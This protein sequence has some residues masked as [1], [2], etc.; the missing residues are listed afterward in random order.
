MRRPI[1]SQNGILK[2]PKIS[3]QQSNTQHLKILYRNCL[4]SIHNIPITI[5]KKLTHMYQVAELTFYIW[6]GVT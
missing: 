2:E 4:F 3:R 5:L 1:L 6:A